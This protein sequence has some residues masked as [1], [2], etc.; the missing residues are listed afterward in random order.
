M[1]AE[2]LDGPGQ[3]E[4]FAVPIG[5]RRVPVNRDAGVGQ[6]RGGRLQRSSIPPRP[7]PNLT[8]EVI[9]QIIGTGGGRVD[10]LPEALTLS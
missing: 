3:V 9:S 7:Y 6:V 5:G 4:A 8:R 1:R 2:N 10:C